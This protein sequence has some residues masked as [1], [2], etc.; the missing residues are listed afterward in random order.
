MAISGIKD[1]DV[2]VKFYSHSTEEGQAKVLEVSRIWWYDKGHIYVV[3]DVV[4]GAFWAQKLP[5]PCLSAI[6]FAKQNY[7]EAYPKIPG[8]QYLI[9]RG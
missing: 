4:E 2:L 1:V 7:P 9:I 8:T 6:S 3:E 5:S